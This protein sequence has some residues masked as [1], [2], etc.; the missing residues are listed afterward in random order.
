[1][2]GEQVGAPN[3]VQEVRDIIAS[4]DLNPA[5]IARLSHLAG[6]V[7]VVEHFVRKYWKA[8]KDID[9]GVALEDDSD[10]R[11]AEFLR[12]EFGG[13]VAKPIRRLMTTRYGFNPSDIE[14]LRDEVIIQAYFGLFGYITGSFTDEAVGRQFSRPLTKLGGRSRLDLVREGDLGPV[15]EHSRS[16]LVEG[17]T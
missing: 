5:S 15:M 11:V 10:Y 3:Q 1:M 8:Q 16:N 13:V 17:G 7:E 9:A 6:Q 2:S 4:G 12:S 14:G